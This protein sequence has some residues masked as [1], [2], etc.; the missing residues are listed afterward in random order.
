VNVPFTFVTRYLQNRYE[1]PKG[2]YAPG[3]EALITVDEEAG[4]ITFSDS[5]TGELFATHNIAIGV[6][7]K[8]ISL[9][10]NANR[11]QETKYDELKNKV[12]AMFDDVNLAC[13]YIDELLKK[14]PRIDW[15]ELYVN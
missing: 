1:V 2:T 3:R 5:V 8:K 12:L 10:K 14:Y 15:R 4:T 13:E 9:S 6:V 7:G 11:F